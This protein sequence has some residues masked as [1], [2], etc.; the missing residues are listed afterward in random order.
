M[1]LFVSKSV[2]FGPWLGEFGWEL[3]WQ[4]ECRGLAKEYDH[5]Y[6]MTTEQNY[7]LYADFSNLIPLPWPNA[8][9]KKSGIY[10]DDHGLGTVE[11]AR[12][13]A[14][15]INGCSLIKPDDVFDPFSYQYVPS[16]NSQFIDYGSSKKNSYYCI[17]ARNR[18]LASERNWGARQWDELTEALLA[19]GLKVVA[20]GGGESYCPVGAINNLGL[21]IRATMGVMKG[22]RIVLGESS[23]PMHLAMLTASPVIVWWTG[24]SDNVNKVRYETHW[25]FHGSPVATLG[26]FGQKISSLEIMDKLNEFY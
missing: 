16:E 4:G 19:T 7:Y 2:L 14:K 23:G 26:E 5:A 20:I 21:D 10:A 13:I 1:G 3:V 22:A 9:K 24:A 15:S 25:N 8:I 11:Y 18:S 17:H 6:V 12:S